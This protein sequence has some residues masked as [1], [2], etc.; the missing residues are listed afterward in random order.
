MN[1][2]KILT[3]RKIFM[4]LYRINLLHSQKKKV[5]PYAEK[6][7][8]VDYKKIVHSSGLGKSLHLVCKIYNSKHL[9]CCDES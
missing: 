7:T 1:S 8:L 5:V 4:W 3:L 6:V 9:R 2:I